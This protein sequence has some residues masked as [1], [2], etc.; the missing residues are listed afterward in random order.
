MSVAD[1]S[2]SAGH[3]RWVL[4]CSWAEDGVMTGVGVAPREPLF[5]V[6]S[7]GPDPVA[8]DTALAAVLGYARGRRPL[9]FRSLGVSQGRWVSVPA[10]GW[11]RF[12]AR[13]VEAPGDL[14]ILVAEGLHGRLD[15]AGW[16]DVQD[17]LARVCAV[18]EAA[19]DRAGGRSFW[20]C[21]PTRCP[22]SASRAPWGRCCGRSDARAGA[23]PTTSPRRYT[24]DA[25]PS[26]RT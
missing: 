4:S 9:R 24:T 15:R 11:S 16:H 3:G 6:P 18:A 5:R 21:P 7:V 8:L 2:S 26:S 22:C 17:A 12:D 20:S 1:R 23:I 25:P 13:P 10:F 14:D 19:A